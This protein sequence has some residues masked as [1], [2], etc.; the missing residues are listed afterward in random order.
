MT[1][2][3]RLPCDTC[4]H[5][6]FTVRFPSTLD[7]GL[8]DSDFTVFGELGEYPQIVECKNCGLNYANP[9]DDGTALAKK[10]S[11]MSVAE[12]L[13]AEESRRQITERD[14]RVV[15]RLA[16]PSGRVLDIGCSAG[17]FLRS[18][19]EGWA[20]YGIEPSKAAASEARKRVPSGEI[21][22]A[23]L[24]S[25]KLTVQTFDLITMWD[26]I[27]H[28]DSPK[29]ALQTVRSMLAPDGHLVM[30]TPDIGSLMARAMGRRWPHLIRAHLY[31]YDKKT[32][33]LLAQAAGLKVISISRYTR[34]FKISYVMR[35]IG[36]VADEAAL[37]KRLGMLDVTVPILTGDSMQ[38][39]LKRD[40]ARS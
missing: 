22:N 39:V 32:L 25:A 17:L 20:K 18:L 13:V 29:A 10:Y 19:G 27:E 24:D 12:Y 28:V 5:T 6:A 40:E 35:R 9:R 34:F 15:E 16:G 2:L 7:R 38:V 11:V 36:L 30:V 14:A 23:T 31:Y 8:D 1:D 21:V 33:R 3:V 4:G 26:V 37:S